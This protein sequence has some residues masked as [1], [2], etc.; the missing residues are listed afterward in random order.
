MKTTKKCH[1]CGHIGPW[2][3]AGLWYICARCESVVADR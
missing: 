1:R 3:A 2:L